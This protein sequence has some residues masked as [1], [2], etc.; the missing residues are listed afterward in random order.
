M[1]KVCRQTQPADFYHKSRTFNGPEAPDYIHKCWDLRERLGKLCGKG[2][3][4]LGSRY[5]G[6]GINGA[7]GCP[8]EEIQKIEIISHVMES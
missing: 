5:M 1:V 6:H 7:G 2:K 8:C 3:R 4:C